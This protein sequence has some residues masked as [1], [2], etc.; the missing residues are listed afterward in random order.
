MNRILLALTLSAVLLG[1]APGDDPWQSSE[2]MQPKELAEKLQATGEVKPPIFY[3]GFPVLYRGGPHIASAALTGPCSKSEGLAELKKAVG[4]L[5]RDH[6]LVI[7]CGCCPFVKCPNIRPAYQ[8]LHD[9]GFSQLKV[10]YIETNLHTDWVTKGYP[11]EGKS[12]IKQSAES[13]Q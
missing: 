8:A 9:M 12:T 5:P 13:Q 6:E 3:V 7:Y 4:N 1:F 11:V 10:L 2:L